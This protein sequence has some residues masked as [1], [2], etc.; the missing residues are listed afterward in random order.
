M[1]HLDFLSDSPKLF[2]FQ[3]ASNKTFFGGVL[4]LLY[5]IFMFILCLVYIIDFFINDDYEVES[6]LIISSKIKTVNMISK[7]NPNINFKLGLTNSNGNQADKRLKIIDI[8]DEFVPRDIEFKKTVSEFF[9]GIFYECEDN[10]ENCTI[11]EDL[12]N[13]RGIVFTIE[14]DSF[15]LANQDNPPLLEN[16]RFL[17][18]FLSFD[19]TALVQLNWNVIKYKEQE[20]TFLRI[21][22]FIY[23]LFRKDINNEYINGYLNYY[24]SAF[25]NHKPFKIN[26][27]NNIL[28]GQI[29]I[30]NKFNSEYTEY[31]RRYINS[32][33]DLLA[34]VGALFS[35]ILSFFKFCF[36]YY[37]NNF[38]NYKTLEKIFV[39]KMKTNDRKFE[40]I[41]MSI[42][43]DNSS[44][45]NK[46]SSSLINESPKEKNL[47]KDDSSNINK[48]SSPLINES[49][50]EQNNIIEND[51]EDFINEKKIS[52]KPHFWDFFL[53]NWLCECCIKSNK[54]KIIKISIEIISKYMSI[55]SLLYNQ[56][57]LENLLKDYKWNNPML[58]NLK[59]N[60]FINRYR[61]LL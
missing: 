35:T 11:P 37:S 29:S 22:K 1:K 59:A 39:N 16:K 31:K 15:E 5:I 38:D 28:I 17:S 50:K 49:S 21:K 8:N 45:N 24:F 47:I 32:F 58:N 54:Q 55:E 4:F 33:W 34:K 6:S 60:D 10:N 7:E 3:K 19:L 36:K 30:F 44:K 48:I 27:K 53:Q 42:N 51:I 9:V 2:L 52:K 14:Y 56:L 18:F 46:I 61:Q 13:E 57:I 20:G 41:E 26:N 43:D 23:G 25:S 40:T 12:K